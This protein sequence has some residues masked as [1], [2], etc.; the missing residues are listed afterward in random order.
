MDYTEGEPARI[1]VLIGDFIASSVDLRLLKIDDVFY[2]TD[3]GP[4][5]KTCTSSLHKFLI[6]EYI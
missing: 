3:A 1:S 2:I 5:T 6:H 4:Y